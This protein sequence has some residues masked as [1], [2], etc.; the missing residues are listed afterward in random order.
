MTNVKVS[1]VVPVYNVE[2]YITKCIT[3]LMKQTFDNFEVLIIDDGSLDCSINIANDVIT[4]DPRFTIY[5]KIN[6][7]LSDARN[8][9]IERAEGEF[10]SFLDSDDFYHPDFLKKMWDKINKEKSDIVI[11]DVEL[12]NESFVKV[13]TQC[14]K[15]KKLISGKSAL[16]DTSILNMAQNKLYKKTLFNNVKY[17]V[18]YFYEDR[19]TTYK[20]FFKSKSISF[21][22]E[23]LFFYLQ[24]E[25]SITRGLSSDKLT[26]PLKILN[27]IKVFLDLNG[28]FDE[29]KQRYI[30]NYLLA[31]LS[32]SVQIAN[33]SSNYQNE[34]KGYLSKID[35]EY[36][37]FKE[38]LNF[39]NFQVKNFALVIL[40]VN[41]KLFKFLAV[42][43]KKI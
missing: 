41:M 36:F 13:R 25:N 23:S 11:C 2:K 35:N 30:K 40:K 38:L 3:S 19:A 12:V 37:N 1:V 42:R 17:P 9:G 32:S 16:L 6:G 31:V 27:E 18:G 22:N 26:D 10:I 5:H 39:R 15:H 28:I 14:N 4:D 29:Y 33:Y 20:L 43:A 8:Y 7:G 34:L 24:R 21:L